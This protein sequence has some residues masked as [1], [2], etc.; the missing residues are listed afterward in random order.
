[1]YNG[2]GDLDEAYFCSALSVLLIDF[3]LLFLTKCDRPLIVEE[4]E[5]GERRTISTPAAASMLLLPRYGASVGL[6]AVMEIVAISAF[7]G[8]G[9]KLSSESMGIMYRRFHPLESC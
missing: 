8:L 4:K 5:D 1:M 7:R 6:C 3:A 9:G 2:F